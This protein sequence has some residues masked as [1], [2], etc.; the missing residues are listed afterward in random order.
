MSPLLP[1][2]SR[3]TV[4]LIKKPSYSDVVSIY[5]EHLV[6]V[7]F[8]ILI[9]PLIVTSLTLIF[10]LQFLIINILMYCMSCLCIEKNIVVNLIIWFMISDIPS[11][12]NLLY[13][14]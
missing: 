13:K 5:F 14:Y 3:W 9:I 6:Q 12:G 7:F 4:L 2:P 1:D 11:Y 10:I 8:L